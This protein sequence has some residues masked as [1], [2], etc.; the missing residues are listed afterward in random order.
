MAANSAS[1]RMLFARAPSS[2]ISRHF[3]CW[4]IRASSARIR[5][6]VISSPFTK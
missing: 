5:A 6:S 4:R 1:A 3:R 2:G